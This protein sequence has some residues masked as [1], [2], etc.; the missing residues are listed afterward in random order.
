MKRSTPIITI[1]FVITI[2]ITVPCYAQK[3][4][5]SQ[6]DE[7]AI[8]YRYQPPNAKGI[9][10]STP[11]SF[12]QRSYLIAGG[13]IQNFWNIASSQNQAGYGLKGNM[14]WGGWISPIHGIEISA[15]IGVLPFNGWRK[16]LINKDE[17]YPS[18]IKQYGVDINY[19]FHITNYAYHREDISKIE[20]IWLAG[21]H[22]HKNKKQSY[23]L[24][25]S[26]R[27][28]INPIANLGIYIEPQISVNDKH[29]AA[30]YGG[31]S[32]AYITPSISAGFIVRFD[33]TRKGRY[34]KYANGKGDNG[35][36]NDN[37]KQLFAI[38][39]NLLLWMIA[40][41]NIAVE[42]PIQ[43]KFSIGL[44]Y[45]SPWYS[46]KD[47]G[48]TY[49]LIMGQL[50]GRYWLGNRK[51]RNIMTGWFAG[52][53]M[54]G[55]YYDLLWDKKDEGAQGELNI[56]IGASMGYAHEIN[57]SGSLRMEYA[58]GAGITRSN[59]RKYHWDG[60]DY[61]LD[62]PSPQSWHTLRV[63]LTQAKVSV[64]WMFTRKTKKGGK[65]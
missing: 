27:A 38:K 62:A 29:L 22:F 58:I 13:G 33:G 45:M 39:S 61:V 47:T 31:R 9:R 5:V 49:Q 59:Y 19:M 32:R 44:D 18:L 12:L 64:V 48:F 3:A 4:G 21:A 63:G 35:N 52:L 54:G 41:P 34:F 8:L 11:K 60:L 42:I 16:N 53:Y 23:G 2:I 40:A 6:V 37:R 50:E 46:N 20:V 24:Q 30:S 25:T 43:D 57:K 51:T 17:L 14:G 56:S 36:N 7:S 55:G 28:V 26:L 15:N 65:R 1:V 10:F